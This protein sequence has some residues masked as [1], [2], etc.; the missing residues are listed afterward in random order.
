MGSPQLENL[1]HI[2]QLKEESPAR[3]EL[4]GLIRSGN[5]RLKDAQLKHNEPASELPAEAR[6]FTTP[7]MPVT[8]D[9]RANIGRQRRDW[10]LEPRATLRHAT[11]SC[12]TFYSP[13]G[14]IFSTSIS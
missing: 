12:V 2:R 11:R 5:L 7:C 13:Q 9:A 4:D 3:A 14:E 10:T 6:P 1:A 8:H